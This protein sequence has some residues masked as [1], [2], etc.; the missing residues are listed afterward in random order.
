MVR[1]IRV[2]DELWS[3]VIEAALRGG[4]SASAVLRAPIDQL[5]KPERK[6]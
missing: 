2:S 1:S 4:T 5:P 6:A 3:R